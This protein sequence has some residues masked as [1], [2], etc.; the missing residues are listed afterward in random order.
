MSDEKPQASMFNSGSLIGAAVMGV[1]GAIVMALTGGFSLGGL[2]LLLGAAGLGAVAGG[3]AQNAGDRA[4]VKVAAKEGAVAAE[5]TAPEVEVAPPART[6]KREVDAPRKTDDE[7]E[8]APVIAP[9]TIKENKKTKKLF[10]LPAMVAPENS[11]AGFY[12]LPI[13]FANAFKAETSQ[14]D[15]LTEI[16]KHSL[17]LPKTGY[18]PYE[19]DHDKNTFFPISLEGVNDAAFAERNRDIQDN[20]PVELRAN[21][22][23]LRGTFN[24]GTQAVDVKELL[25]NFSSESGTGMVFIIP[26]DMPLSMRFNDNKMMQQD[27]DTYFLKNEEA[28]RERFSHQPGATDFIDSFVRVAIG[29]AEASIPQPKSAIETALIQYKDGYVPKDTAGGIKVPVTEMVAKS[30]DLGVA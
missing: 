19:Y 14:R 3:V 7:P 28:L 11:E 23:V 5:G 26:K 21:D 25:G 30:G 12:K 4:K 18:K 24:K 17:Y 15:A 9:Q 16:E 27:F 29:R 10:H 22:I 13:P 2:A 20:S 6:K 8:A 1:I